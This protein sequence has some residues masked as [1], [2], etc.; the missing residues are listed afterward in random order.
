MLT[1]PLVFTGTNDV[2]V[3]F[4]LHHPFCFTS[5][6][7]GYLLAVSFITK[8]VG[9][10]IGLPIMSNILNLSDSV[11]TSSGI[12][13]NIASTVFL[14]FTRNKWQTFVGKFQT[15]YVQILIKFGTNFK[16]QDS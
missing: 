2:I 4:V 10:F 11:I 14:A 3:L 12:L 1:F 5:S 7:I 9:V 15:S 6:M 8:S 16:N 13:T